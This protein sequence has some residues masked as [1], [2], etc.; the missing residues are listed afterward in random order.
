[1]TKRPDIFK[2]FSDLP[3]ARAMN[4]ALMVGILEGDLEKVKTA[5]QNGA[6]V[7]FVYPVGDVLTGNDKTTP[8]IEASW[9]TLNQGEAVFDYLL[10]FD[11]INVNAADGS[12][13][14]AL[15]KA[16]SM[17]MKPERIRKL[18]DKGAEPLL[19]DNDGDIPITL[20][21]ETEQHEIFE[22]LFDE[23]EKKAH[24]Q[25]RKLNRELGKNKYKF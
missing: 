19:E 12:G 7:N 24:A 13:Y 16:V 23:V 3:K 18:L 2:S 4:K 9:R 11:N 5:V 14:T 1:M 25:I 22:M 17:E 20:A 8:L 10:S 15:N 6:D 21:L